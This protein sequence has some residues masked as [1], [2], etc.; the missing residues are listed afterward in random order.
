MHRWTVGVFVAA[1]CGLMPVT[2][3]AM[4][5]EYSAKM[6]IYESQGGT[7][8]GQV[9]VSKGKMRFDTPL[10]GNITRQDLNLTWVL[11]PDQQMYLE[12][13]LDV[14]AMRQTSSKVPGEVERKPLGKETVDGVETEKYLITYTEGP[15][16]LQMHQWLGPEGLPRKLEALDGSWRIEYRDLKPGSPDPSVFEVPAGYQ[17]MTVPRYDD[18][19]ALIE[20]AREAAQE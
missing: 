14:T 7:A 11:M 8:E 1:L 6:V 3:A 16:T 20:Q 5:G 12:Q 9:Y 18:M 13:A 19:A 10:G 4:D 2:A 17:K 15:H